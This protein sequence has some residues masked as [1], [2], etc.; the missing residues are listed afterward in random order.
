MDPR[1]YRNLVVSLYD[2]AMGTAAWNESLSL[3]G[4]VLSSRVLV[5]FSQM[6]GQSQ[7][8]FLGGIGI[9]PAAVQQYVDYFA[10]RN[11]LMAHGAALHR[12]GVGRTSE[13]ICHPAM[14]LGSE[15]YNDF[16]RPLDIRYSA[17]LTALRDEHCAIHV[18]AFREH[19]ASA[20]D[21]ADLRVLA[22]VYPH[23]RRALQVYL[24]LADSEQRRASFEQVTVGTSKGMAFLNTARKPVYLNSAL[25]EMLDSRDGLQPSSHGITAT[26]TRAAKALRAAIDDAGRGTCGGIVDVPRPSGLDPYVVV[27]SPVLRRLGFVGSAQAT[28]LLVVTD[29]ARLAAPAFEVLR[30]RYGLTRMEGQV[31]STFATGADLDEIAGRFHISV[32]TART[33]LKRIL[34]KTNTSR[35]AALMRRLL[36]DLT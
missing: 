22:D 27:V 14:L 5:L 21:D 11:V 35:Q 17:A 2:A 23:L 12:E 3:L 18:S 10:A 24:Q 32:H 9:Q 26:D 7:S 30:K 1:D 4:D 28:V 15:Y 34:A 8:T 29:P 25:Q 13:T 36:I 6:P 19:R 16:M 33:H 20:F 31:A